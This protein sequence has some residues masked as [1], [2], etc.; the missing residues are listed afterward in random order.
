M[1]PWTR[2][3]EGKTKGGD[4]RYHLQAV[5]EQI[6]DQERMI[7]FRLCIWLIGRVLI[8]LVGA[9]KAKKKW[10]VMSGEEVCKIEFGNRH[11]W[12]WPNIQLSVANRNWCLATIWKCRYAA[13]TKG[14]LVNFL[15]IFLLHSFLFSFNKLLTCCR[16][17]EADRNEHYRVLVLK[18]FIVHLESRQVTRYCIS[19]P[20]CQDFL[21][22]WFPL[23]HTNTKSD[24][25]VK[26]C[27]LRYTQDNACI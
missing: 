9:Q 20:Y 25:Q 13:W 2:A 11:I 14:L 16:C 3:L 12:C 19:G 21:Y 17:Y 26:K 24:R 4:V 23:K 8:L 10:W 18:I 6:R 7:K 15:Y 5:L 22:L 1:V 27:N